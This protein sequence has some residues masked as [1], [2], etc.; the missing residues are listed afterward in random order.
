MKISIIS[1]VLNEEKNIEKF[2]T[3]IINQTKRPNEFIIVDGGSKDKTYEILKK[4]SRKDGWIKAYQ[5]KNANISQGRN[6]AIL[7]TK[8][9]IIAVCDAGG[10]YK[11]DWLEKLSKG[12]NGQVSFGSDK[13]LI[14]TEFHRKLAKVILHKNVEGSS[15]NMIFTKKIWKDVGGYPEDLKI[16]ED[17][18]FDER[19]KRKGYKISRVPDAVCY[20]EMRDS[21]EDVKKQFYNYGY[22]DGRSYRKYRL[23]PTKHKLAVILTLIITPTYPIIYIIFK[24]S[25]YMEIYMTKRFGYLNGFLRGFFGKWKK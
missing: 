21:L 17:T 13:P 14:K 8:N 1:T 16:G 9:D 6:Y 12:F 2:M 18:L 7:K 23:L 11:K 3:S 25:T 22:W 24:F 4:F 19:I 15:R 10:E 20:W 5:K